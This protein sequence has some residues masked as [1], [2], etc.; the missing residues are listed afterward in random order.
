MS[1]C[2]RTGLREQPMG[3]ELMIVDDVADKVHILNPTSAFI[4]R[5]LD[6]TTD[7]SRIE[8]RLRDRF[9]APPEYDVAGL[10][11]RA[12]A[13]FAEKNLVTRGEVEP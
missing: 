7:P 3:D 5:C 1:F 9:S 4:W 2:K 12:M 11:G 10:I 6:E 8:A 13:Q